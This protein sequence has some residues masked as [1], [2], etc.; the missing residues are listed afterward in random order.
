MCQG[1]LALDLFV[2]SVLRG[3]VIVALFCCVLFLCVFVFITVDWFVCDYVCTLFYYV[4]RDISDVLSL[5]CI[6]IM[7]LMFVCV[8]CCCVCRC[9]HIVWLCVVLLVCPCV[10][11]CGVVFAYVCLHVCLLPL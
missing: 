7:C 6:V 2:L 8:C 3:L 4:L 5:L 1:L 10:F 11:R 9:A